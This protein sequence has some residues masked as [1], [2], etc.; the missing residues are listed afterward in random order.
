[1]IDIYNDFKMIDISSDNVEGENGQI[2]KIG[3]YLIGL[4]ECFQK[5]KLFSIV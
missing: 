1:M 2:K 3:I 5:K 4:Y